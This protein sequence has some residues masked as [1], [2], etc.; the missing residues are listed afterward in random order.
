M[1]SDIEN[2]NVAVS[3]GEVGAKTENELTKVFARHNRV[4][5]GFGQFMLLLMQ[6]PRYGK[7]TV[8]EL[9]H[10]VLEPLAKG[11][12]LL[13][14]PTQK[15]AGVQGVTVGAAIWAKV[16]PEVDD[17][18]RDQIKRKVFPVGVA[19]GDWNSG[20]IHWLFDIIAPDVRLIG[21][22]F[23]NVKNHLKGHELFVHPTL[24]Q[25]VQSRE[26]TR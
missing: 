3:S 19:P 23:E 26:R 17:K 7:L 12:I 25:F 9:S 18:I 4:A 6:A 20:D 14:R 8:S 21:F 11:N 5:E 15:Y 13:S 22:T 24:E 10:S 1:T 2:I 16:S